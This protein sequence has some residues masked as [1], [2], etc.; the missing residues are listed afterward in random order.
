MLEC[1]FRLFFMHFE[2]ENIKDVASL[3]LSL[4]VN[5]IICIQEVI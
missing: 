4:F 1:V 5:M 3:S 2:E